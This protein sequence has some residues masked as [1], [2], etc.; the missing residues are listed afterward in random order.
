[1]TSFNA[2]DPAVP[3]AAP[4]LLICLD[5]YVYFFCYKSICVELLSLTIKIFLINAPAPHS[6]LAIEPLTVCSVV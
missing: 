2:L 6:D 1:M 4:G 5:R 3:E